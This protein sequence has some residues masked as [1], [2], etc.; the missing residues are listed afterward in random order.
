MH[1]ISMAPQSP[2]VCDSLSVFL[3]FLCIEDFEKHWSDVLQNVSQVGY[4]LCFLMISLGLCVR[5]KH[6]KRQMTFSLLHIICMHV[7][8]V[9]FDSLRPHGLQLIYPWKFPGKNTGLGCHF[10][11]QGLFPTQGLNP[12][13]LGLLHWQVGSL[14]PHYLGRPDIIFGTN[15]QHD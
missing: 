7:C 2:L 10:L 11:L 14:P 13:L 9:I 12:S 1:L 15:Y 3:H 4:V 5:G 6:T 8:S